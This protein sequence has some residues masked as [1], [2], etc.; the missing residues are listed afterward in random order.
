MVVAFFTA[1]FFAAGFATDFFVAGFFVLAFFV[2]VF[3]WLSL[4]QFSSL[5][6]LVVVLAADFF[7][8]VAFVVLSSLQ[9]LFLWALAYLNPL[10]LPA[11][12]LLELQLGNPHPQRCCS[13]FS[14][15]WLLCATGQAC[16]RLESSLPRYNF[17]GFFC[18]LFISPK[19]FRK[20]RLS[21]VVLALD[22]RLLYI[23]FRSCTRS[24]S[25]SCLMIIGISERTG[26][27]LGCK[28]AQQLLW[29]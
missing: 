27:P 6:V 11:L 26:S 29:L 12:F 16:E 18:M 15:G 13:C 3:S 24:A 20:E 22:P 25:A 4:Q 28:E 19:Q 17:H 8:A 1:V 23:V 14:L 7:A 2:V 21:F 10:F 9:P 5:L